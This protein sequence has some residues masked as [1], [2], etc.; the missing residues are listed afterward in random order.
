MRKN[1][2][3]WN[4]QP[5]DKNGVGIIPNGTSGSLEQPK[6]PDGFRFEDLRCIEEV[7]EF[8]EKNYVE[9]V[10]AEHMLRY[11]S[12]FL[13]WVIDCGGEK[14]KYCIVLRLCGR[15][16][17]FIFGKEHHVVIRGEK[18]RAIGVNFLCVAQEM[19]G[20]RLAPI[21]IKEITRRANVDG[22]FKG[23]FTSGTELFFNVSH[24]RYYHRPL[25]AENLFMSR[26]S[27]RIMKIRET[28]VRRGTRIAEERDMKEIERL[29]MEESKRYMLYEEMGSSDIISALK[30]VKNVVYTYVHE[31]DGCIDGFGA[32][33]IIETIE[34]KSRR[35]V[36][37]GYLYYRGGKD[38]T[39]MVE[40]LIYFAQKEGCDVFNCLDIMENSLFLE[41]LGFFPGSG[42]L[43]YYL[44]NWSSGEVPKD[45]VFF[46]LP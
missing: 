10:H 37:G 16:V 8:L 27:D 21:L 24:G 36:Q 41:G 19:R 42:E 17:G 2:E 35:S 31:D 39:K 3:F 7:T 6:L 22:I 20:R 15:M 28:R 34:K 9:D 18:N 13:K 14:K 4:T 23:V 30:P 12:N 46:I 26:F 25:N 38:N 32:F 45:K 11:S 29:Y 33:L 40:D 43:R 1:H 5:V 44:Y